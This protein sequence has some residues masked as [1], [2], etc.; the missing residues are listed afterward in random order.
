MHI[1]LNMKVSKQVLR[2]IALEL[3]SQEVSQYEYTYMFYYLPYSRTKMPWAIT[4]YVPTLDVEIMGLTA[5]R[6]QF[7]VSQAVS[8]PENSELIGELGG[9]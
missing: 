4:H 2:E 5:D 3:K 6:E 7:L 9:R 1:R 8:L